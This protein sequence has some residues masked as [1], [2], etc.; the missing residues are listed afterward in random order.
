MSISFNEKIEFLA[1]T[2]GLDVVRA[3][4]ECPNAFIAWYE[5]GSSS[6][7]KE[8]LQDDDYSKVY[9][10]DLVDHCIETSNSDY[11]FWD[12]LSAC[13]SGFVIDSNPYIEEDEDEE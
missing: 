12:N 8:Y 11:E 1:E 9:F 2:Y 4:C 3:M 6:T 10:Y 13:L 5:N 7:V